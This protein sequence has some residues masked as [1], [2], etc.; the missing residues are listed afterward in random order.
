MPPLDK[1]HQLERRARTIVESLQGT[2]SRGIGMCCCPAHDDRTPSLSVTLGRKA[3]LFHCFAGCSNEEVIAAL[4]RQGVRSRDL[5]DG[6]GAVAA[7]RLEERT[8]NS[9]ARR[10]WHSA[11]AI[12]DGPAEGYLAQRGILR[13]SDQLRY[14]ERTPLGPRGAVQFLPAMLAAVTTDIGIIAIHRTFLDAPNAKLAGFDRPKR[15]L[16]SLGC[17]AV[18]LAPPAAGRLG[19][20]EGIE[21]ALSAMQLFGVPCWAT[22]GNERF[23]LVTIP[24]SVRELHLFIDNDAGGE[25]ADQR[26]RRAYSPSGRVIQTRAPESIGFDWNDEL[27]ARVARKT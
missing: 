15:A 8:F 26:A 11:T 22:L 17:G 18:R 14:L 16:G 20:A 6:S 10:L 4:D 1:V 13:A 19:L 9:N 25:L 27:K 24:E 12:S 5:F 7:D 2:W 21:S 23:G 3:I